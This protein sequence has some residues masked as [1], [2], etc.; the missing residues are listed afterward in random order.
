MT[1]ENLTAIIYVAN[2][3][4]KTI[5]P[6][7]FRDYLD[8]YGRDLCTSP[9]GV[10]NRLFSK[11]VENEAGEIEYQI[12]SWGTL[13]NNLHYTGNAFLSEEDAELFLYDCAE[14]EADSNVNALPYYATEDEAIQSLA[15]GLGRDKD[16]VARYLRLKVK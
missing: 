2:R 3:E 5:E 1:Q 7:T 11:E 12:W 8:E 10:T 15:D 6:S 4:E 13:G 9:R 16:V 14:Q